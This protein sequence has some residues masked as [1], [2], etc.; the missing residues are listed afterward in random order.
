MWFDYQ[1]DN[2]PQETKMT[3]NLTTVGHRTVINNEQS[4]YRIGPELTCKT[5]QTKK[6]MALFI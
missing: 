1:C 3:Q 4:P 6:L 2:S 5:I